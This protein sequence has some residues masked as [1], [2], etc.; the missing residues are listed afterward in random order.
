MNQKL[1][2]FSAL[3]IAAIFV[4]GSAMAQSSLSA[5]GDE[6][7]I[8]RVD[9]AYPFQLVPTTNIW[10]QLLIDTATGRV[11]QVQFSLS[12]NAPAGKWVINDSI[13]LPPGSNPKNG[14]FTLYP[15]QNMYTF[16]LLDREDSRIW[17]LQWSAE[18]ANRGI[19]RSIAQLDDVKPKNSR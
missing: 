3:S 12:D 13:L 8:G 18:P 4:S 9:T 14:R 17:Q 7:R 10:T 6:A 19:I 11:W 15:T 2:L 5:L 16:L 1:G